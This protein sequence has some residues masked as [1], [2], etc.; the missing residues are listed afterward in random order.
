MLVAIKI[1]LFHVG[2]SQQCPVAR[3]ILCVVTLYRPHFFA[4]ANADLFTFPYFE[5]GYKNLCPKYLTKKFAK[6]GHM[7]ICEENMA[8]WGIPKKRTKKTAQRR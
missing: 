5:C 4:Y 6:Y 1:F 7:G 8:K 3:S 2:H